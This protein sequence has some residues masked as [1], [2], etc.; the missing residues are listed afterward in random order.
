MWIE[1]IVIGVIVGLIRGGRM[2]QLEVM[3]VNGLFLIIIGLL[4][5]LIPFFLHKIVWISE[6]SL[7]F[8]LA[9]VGLA[10]V[11][12]VLN[13]RKKGMWLVFLGAVVNTAVIWFNDLKMP[14]RLAQATGA[15]YIQMKLA[16]QSGEIVN[17]VLLEEASHW[18]KYLGKVLPFPSFYPLTQIIGLGDV[19]IAVG[20][21][22]FIQSEMNNNRM[23]SQGMYLSKNYSKRYY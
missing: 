2:N 11:A 4:L 15:K 5:Q 14:V 8:I 9:G 20:I 10:L 1:A 6:Y 19:L 7:M 21:V 16:I 22:W 3:H 17:Y 23:F 13:I 12:V 18:T